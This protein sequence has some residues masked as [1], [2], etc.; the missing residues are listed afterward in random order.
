MMEAIED[1]AKFHRM[2]DSPVCDEPAFPAQLRRDLRRRLIAEEFREFETAE[3]AND[4][5]GVA[6]ALADLI[7]VCIGTALEYGI[8]LEAVWDE[9]QLTNMRKGV[10]GKV[11]KDALGKI[12]KPD[13]WTPPQI[14]E[15]LDLYR[16]PLTVQADHHDEK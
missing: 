13:G 1:V 11:V 2:T 5:T 15:I 9:V 12:R 14:A 4:L 6:D 8:P 3:L 16:T 10:N 7:Y